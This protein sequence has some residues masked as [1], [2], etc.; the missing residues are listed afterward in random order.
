M[1]NNGGVSSPETPALGKRAERRPRDMALSLGI[2]IVPIVLVMLF[3]NVVLDGSEPGDFD[4]GPAIES[5]RRAELFD[6]SEP[7]DLGDDWHVQSATFKRDGSETTATLRVGYAAPSSEPLQLIES[8]VATATLIPA[9]LGADP[10]AT[11]THE[12][13]GRRWQQYSAR[14]GETALVVLEEKR[15]LIVIGQAGPDELKEF[16]AKL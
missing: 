4:A 3:W 11:G 5:A 10:Q 14:D 15:T 12:A 7:R 6:I 2:L 1:V 8:N 13:G 16:V 9:E